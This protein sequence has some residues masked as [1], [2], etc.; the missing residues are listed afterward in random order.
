MNPFEEED[1]EVKV[2]ETKNMS[3][4]LNNVEIWLDIKGRHKNTFITG[5]NFETNILNEHLTNLKKK[6]GC[7]GSLSELL[8]DGENKKVLKLQG[9]HIDNIQTFLTSINITNFITRDFKS[10]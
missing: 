10:I 7:N 9:D 2:D 6:H 5:L 8:I 3:L 4:K 1:D